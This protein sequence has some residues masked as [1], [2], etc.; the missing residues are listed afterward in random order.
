MPIGIYKRTKFHKDIT[1]K[2]IKNISK[3]MISQYDIQ[4]NFIRNIFSR[5]NENWEN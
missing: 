3:K 5:L 2:T 4:W 1:S